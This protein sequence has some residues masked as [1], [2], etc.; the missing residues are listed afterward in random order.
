MANEDPNSAISRL[1]DEIAANESLDRLPDLTAVMAATPQMRRFYYSEA[2]RQL[3][4]RRFYFSKADNCMVFEPDGVTRMKAVAWLGNYDAGQPLQRIL[5]ANF[6]QGG[7]V[8]IKSMKTALV[9]SPAT[10][11][12]FK[13][14]IEEA[15]EAATKKP[16]PK[17]IELEPKK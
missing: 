12:A 15:E 17:R 2:V 7:L 13:R 6:G 9:E 16:D 4:A 11:S 8:D 3:G 1:A 14:M 10:R 5:Q